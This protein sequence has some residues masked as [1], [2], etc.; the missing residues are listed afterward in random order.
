MIYMND[1]ILNPQI[2]SRLGEIIMQRSIELKPEYVMTVETKGIPLALSTAKAFNIPMV[3]A[4]KEARITEGPAVSI[5]YLSGSTKKI[6]SMSLPKKALPQGARVLI[7]D[8][9]MR[10]GGTVSGL[11]ELAEEVGAEVVGV[12]LFIAAKEPAEKLV[13]E[14]ASL[15]T[16]RGVD[17][18]DKTID[19]VPEVL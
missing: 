10:A 15:L 12:Y 4:R 9:F 16:L 11:C 1:L 8:D 14:Y 3:M 19:I 7:V 5:S 18:N 13:K 6:Q 17:E 2:V